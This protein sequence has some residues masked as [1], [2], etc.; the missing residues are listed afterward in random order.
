M[1][2]PSPFSFVDLFCGGGFG[3]RGAMGAGGSPLLSVDLWDIATATYK[4]NFRSS[5]VRTDRVENVSPSS[6]SARRVDLLLTSPECTN[7]THA[8]GSRPRDDASRDTAFSSLEWVDFLKPKWIVMEN[9]PNMKGWE[10]YAELRSELEGLGYGVTEQVLCASNF[11]VPQRRRRLFVTAARG[12]LPRATVVPRRK[13]Q[14]V[15]AILDPVGT[16]PESDLY[17]PSRAERTIRYAEAA[18]AE[19][20]L[21]SFLVVY[22]GSDKGGGWQRLTDPLRTV[23]T[24]DRFALVRPTGKGWKM[25]MLQPPEL[26][27]AMGLPKSHVFPVGTRRDKVKLCGNGICSPVMTDVIKQLRGT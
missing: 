5:D 21:D 1:S 7:H 14:G 19:V 10:R 16:W 2:K 26:A 9:V 18:M 12:D 11:G 17:S 27:R 15:N 3:A 25:R 8:R 24:L 13:R 6:V 22:Y 20:G 23:T 4:R